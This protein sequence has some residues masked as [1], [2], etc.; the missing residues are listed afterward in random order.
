[1]LRALGIRGVESGGA[2]FLVWVLCSSG[3]IG[4]GKQA[5]GPKVSEVKFRVR[6]G[7]RLRT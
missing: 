6:V 1:M 2:G 4:L 7:L 3:C 5:S